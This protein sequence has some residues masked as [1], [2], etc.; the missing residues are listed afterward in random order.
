MLSGAPSR[1]LELIAMS[2]C[3]YPDKVH[4]KSCGIWTAC[5]TP[6]S[7]FKDYCT[8]WMGQLYTSQL[9]C[10]DQWHS[11]PRPC[12]WRPFAKIAARRCFGEDEVTQLYKE[13]LFINFKKL[14]N[15]EDLSAD[16]SKYSQPHLNYALTVSSWRH[17]QTAWKRKLK[18]GCEEI[19]KLDRAEDVVP[20]FLE[21]STLWQEYHGAVP[22]GQWISYHETQSLGTTGTTKANRRQSVKH[23]TMV[24]E[25]VNRVV[26][27]LGALPVVLFQ[28]FWIIVL[29]TIME[30]NDEFGKGQEE[31]EEGGEESEEEKDQVRR[32]VRSC[33]TWMRATSH[34]LQSM[35]LWWHPDLWTRWKM[36]AVSGSTLR[37]NSK[38]R[39]YLMMFGAWL[40]RVW[41][42][43]VSIVLSVLKLVGGSGKVGGAQLSCKTNWWDKGKEG[44]LVDYLSEVY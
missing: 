1:S 39:S 41:C 2:Y 36:R 8:H 38:S 28:A 42:A 14:F 29:R 34:C 30:G 7:I 27:Q 43:L 31:E 11:C 19:M 26:E 16:M 3:K 22:G 21:A 23:N 20:L 9:E 25:I 17:I 44:I 37:G 40:H 32:L 24:D 5:G 12:Y 15:T 13:M 10:I 35:V 33:L 6:L 4:K 18:C